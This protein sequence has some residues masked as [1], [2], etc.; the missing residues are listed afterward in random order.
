MYSYTGQPDI[1]ESREGT[2]NEISLHI[3][4]VNYF[5]HSLCPSISHCP[6][7]NHFNDDSENKN[8]YYYYFYKAIYE[9]EDVRV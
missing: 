2:R 1:E 6:S 7:L 9:S 5:M 8:K 4:R 3:F